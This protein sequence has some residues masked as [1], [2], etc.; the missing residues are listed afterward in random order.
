MGRAR[1]NRYCIANQ[2]SASLSTVASLV[3]TVAAG[4]GIVRGLIYKS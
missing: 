3:A 1:G 2:A 4:L